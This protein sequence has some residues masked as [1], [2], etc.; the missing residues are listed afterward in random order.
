[1]AKSAET[2]ET[3]D[4]ETAENFDSLNKEIETVDKHLERLRTMEKTMA[5]KSQRVVAEG[6]EAETVSA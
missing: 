5:Q 3:M 4:A 2:G 1:M 6:K